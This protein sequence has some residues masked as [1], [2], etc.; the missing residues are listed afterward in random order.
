M[1]VIRNL[2]ALIVLSIVFSA[3]IFNKLTFADDGAEIPK[4][5]ITGNIS[6]MSS[7]NDKRKISFRY[8]DNGKT[9]ESYARLKIQGSYSLGFEKKN[10]TVDFYEDD[11]YQNKKDADFGWG[12]H[13]KY[14][15]K[16][17]WVD[18]THARN[19]VTA[20]IAAEANE[21]YGLFT[22]TPN[23]GEVDGYPVEVYVNNEFF[24][25]Y[26]LN[27]PKSDWMFNMDKN[28]DALKRAENLVS[29]LESDYRKSIREIDYN[30][31]RSQEFLAKA[32]EAEKTAEVISVKLDQAR[33]Y[34]EALENY[35]DLQNQVL[36]GVYE[37]EE[38]L[39]ITPVE[40]EITTP[41]AVVK[42]ETTPN[43][44]VKDDEAK[45]PVEELSLDEPKDENELKPARD[46]EE[47]SITEFVPEDINKEVVEEI[48]KNQK[49]L[50]E[51]EERETQIE[52]A[53]KEGL[54]QDAGA[55]KD[56]FNKYENPGLKY[57]DK[58]FELKEAPTEVHAGED[59]AKKSK[60]TIPAKEKIAKLFSTFK[61]LVLEEIVEDEPEVKEV[62]DVEEAKEELRIMPDAAEPVEIKPMT[63]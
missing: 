33:K 11:T 6:N 35:V 48:D 34:Y 46:L 5:F 22:S 26:T 62:T 14:T 3:F 7:K 49:E 41:N 4:I 12:Q 55:V 23:Y 29:T 53:Y 54:T 61:N 60:A 8:D 40:E 63:K 57:I 28:N 2:C 25:L 21:Q 47:N 39:G 19:I 32:D 59:Y 58:G 51:E 13:S 17:N 38:E 20:N 36:S 37:M 42:E 10:Y 44:S 50:N 27:I 24:G 52:K 43:A 31:R 45:A 15:L 1:R 16:A 9:F 30:R 56:D 18:K